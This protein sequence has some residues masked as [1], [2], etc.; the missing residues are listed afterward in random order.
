MEQLAAPAV[1]YDHLNRN[2]QPY[3]GHLL[4]EGGT[5]LALFSAGFYGW[6]DVIHMARKNM[7]V[8]CV[9]LNGEKLW[10]M[11]RVYPVGWAFHVQDAWAFA[12]DMVG[13][14]RWDAVSVDPFL[15]D[16]A[17]RALETLDLWLALASKMVTLTVTT[18]T[19]PVAP[20][21]WS[22]QF[23]PRSRIAQWM[24]LQRV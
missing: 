3:P 7:T 16:A 5:G 22:C 19:R 15:G 6:N 13:Y 2:A 24:V 12:H 4:P 9:D 18:K 10:E 1:T 17:Q 8:E 21:G 14:R 11:A 23:F 20:E